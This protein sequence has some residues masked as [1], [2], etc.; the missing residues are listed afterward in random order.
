MSKVAVVAKL[1]CKEGSRDAAVA[2]LAAQVALVSDESGTEVYA[3]HLDDT[4]TVTVWF[5][6]LYVDAESL[7]FHGQTENM[8]ALGPKLAGLMAARPEITRLTPVTAKGLSV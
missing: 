2:V 5:Y 8:K 3:L 1:T 6:E 4:D 7:A